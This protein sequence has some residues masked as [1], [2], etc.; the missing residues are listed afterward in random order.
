MIQPVTVGISYQ[1]TSPLK[2]LSE[3]RSFPIH[4]EQKGWD[5]DQLPGLETLSITI[6]LN[7]TRISVS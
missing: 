7:L 4:K 2:S 1:H 5:S 3:V 6:S